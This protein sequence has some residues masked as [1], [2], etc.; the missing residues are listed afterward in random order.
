MKGFIGNIVIIIIALFA[1]SF[2]FGVDIVGV[3]KHPALMAAVG[4][5][6]KAILAL[7]GLAIDL[8]YYILGFLGDNV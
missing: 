4:A 1:L 7:I 2:V 5:V 8:I 3:L 6:W